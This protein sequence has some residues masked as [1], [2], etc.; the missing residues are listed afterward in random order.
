MIDY[1]FG[2]ELPIFSKPYFQWGLTTNYVGRRF[3][4]RPET[5][6]TMDDARRMME[7]INLQ[8]GAL[9]LAES[10][11]AGRGRA[12]RGWVSPPDVNLYF[13]ILL[14]PPTSALRA[15]SAVTPLALAQ[16]IESITGAKGLRLRPEIKWPN[17]V[18]IDG[19]KVSGILIETEHLPDKVVALVGVGINVNLDAAQYPEIAEIATSLKEALGFAV[20]REE[21]LAAFC[22]EF[23]PLYEQAIAGS[24]EPFQTWKSR[25][26]TLGQDVTV[27]APDGAFSGRAVDVEEDGALIVLTGDSQRVRVEA[28]DVS[29]RPA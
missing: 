10:Q 14:F 25:L 3:V 19:K 8:Q 20:P 18:L 5:E 21:V 11:T 1:Q 6:S 7:R 24:S 26:V 2:D 4:Y 28:G 23:E 13:T 16:T 9:I 15:L 12:G 29:V 17:D 27:S 22:N